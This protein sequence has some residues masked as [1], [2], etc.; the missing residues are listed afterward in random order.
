MSQ[1]GRFGSSSGP[2][3]PSV[4]TSYVT[5]NGTAVP[6]SNVLIVNG[7]N[8]RENN[9]NGIITKGGV[10]GTGTSNEVDV[11]VTN[12][13]VGSATTVGVQTSDMVT[14]VPTVTGTYSIEG[15]IAAYNLTS[16][17]GSGYSLFGTIRFDGTN[18]NLCGTPDLI[19]NEEGAMSTANLTMTVAGANVLISGTGYTGQTINWTAVCLYTYIGA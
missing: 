12:R 16:L 9:V 14:F 18:S 7:K 5:Q 8:S 3:P 19:S 2:L 17:L 15:R 4:A 1:A 6:A 13:M 10:A 11:V